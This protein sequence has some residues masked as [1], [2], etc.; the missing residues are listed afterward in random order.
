M[1]YSLAL[2]TFGAIRV[3]SARD[4]LIETAQAARTR[5]RIAEAGKRGQLCH[6][7]R[8]REIG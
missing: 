2:V 7:G 1:K 4:R 6:V 5:E 3:R 8:Q